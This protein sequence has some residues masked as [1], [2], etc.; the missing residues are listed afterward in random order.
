MAFI[1]IVVMQRKRRINIYNI[2]ISF[3]AFNT[4]EIQNDLIG[5]FLSEN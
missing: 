2:F 5:D 4:F 1:K 3:K